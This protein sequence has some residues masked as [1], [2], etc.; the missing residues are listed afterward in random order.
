MPELRIELPVKN[1]LLLLLLLLLPTPSFAQNLAVW[2]FRMRDGTRTETTSS[3]A[4]E[5]EEALMQG[6]T[7]VVL[8]RR[9]V[10]RL[11]AVIDSEMALQDIDKVSPAG[12]SKLKQL[13]IAVVVF[14]ELFDDVDSG[15]ASIT[16]S[17]QEFSGKKL[18]TKSV[19]MRRGLLRDA[20]SRRE[21]M[22][23]LVQSLSGANSSTGIRDGSPA[24]TASTAKRRHEGEESLKPIRVTG[25]GLAK[26][27]SPKGLR[28]ALAR[29]AAI[30]DAQRQLAERIK[31]Q[32]QAQTETQDLTLMNDKVSTDVTQT[33][34]G[35]R[36]VSERELPDG[37]YEVILELR[38]TFPSDN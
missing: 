9:N 22:T 25:T 28:R 35:A 17:F 15:D 14:G 3:L 33:V 27:N 12:L 16:I 8:E 19:L 26:E 24:D 36:V 6:S 21:R 2:D 11:Q 30:A 34:L 18:L 4:Y 31:V 32:I 20:T 37:G 29:R 10:P 5:F 1:F 13:G 7:Y 23:A 38:Q